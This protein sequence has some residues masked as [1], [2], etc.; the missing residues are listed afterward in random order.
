MASTSTTSITKLNQIEH[1]FEIYLDNDVGTNDNRKYPINPNSIINLTIEDT[2]ADWVSRGTLT[3]LYNPDLDYAYSI[4]PTTGGS[5]D[6]VTGVSSIISRPGHIFRGDGYDYLRIRIKPKLDEADGS[7]LNLKIDDSPHWTVSHLFSIYDMEDIDLPPGAQNQASAQQKCIKLYFWDLWY[8]KLISTVMEYS[9]AESTRANVDDDYDK[10]ANPGTIFTGLAIKEIIEQ[11]LSED[12]SQEKYKETSLGNPT[13]GFAYEATADDENWDEGSAKIFYT[14]PAG[15]TAYDSLMYVLKKHVSS[16]SE[17]KKYDVCILSKE[18]GPLEE[19]VGQFHLVPFS[20]IFKKAG[21]SQTNPLEYQIEHFFVQG[22]TGTNKQAGLTFRAPK[23]DGT[24]PKIDMQTNK[25]GVITSYRFVD[26]APYTNTLEFTNKPVYSFDFKNRTYNIEFTN[27][28]VKAAREF[29][30]KKYISE[31]Y[32]NSAASTEDLFLI[33]LNEDKDT[34]NT[35]PVFSLHGDDADIRQ[36]QGLSKLLKTG[37]FLNTAINFR[38]LGFTSRQSGRFIGIDK[39]EGE[40]EGA[41]P[42]KFY[43]QWF[44]INVKHII[45]SGVYYNDITAVKIHRFDV[46]SSSFEKTL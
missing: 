34:I 44:V 29:I 38:T 15:A 33:T 16:S 45:E 41:F 46:L 36:S 27:N 2:M 1:E 14:A 3:F 11:G 31:L 42:D 17:D 19:D 24:N 13:L 43:G 30:S 39:T 28:S 12:V 40:D 21:K 35:R 32:K 22:Y 26:M 7:G 25:Y 8:Q 23:N 5:V 18:R 4:N 9:T 37:L 10:Y 6:A 20:E